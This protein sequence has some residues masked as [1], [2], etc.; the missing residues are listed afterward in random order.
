MR[1]RRAFSF[2]TKDALFQSSNE[3]QLQPGVLGESEEVLGGDKMIHR[4]MNHRCQGLSPWFKHV[5][6]SEC[7]KT[8]EICHYESKKFHIIPCHNLA[9]QK[10]LV[11]IVKDMVPLLGDRQ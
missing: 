11:L 5:F 9:V 1:K 10:Q 2:T 3:P 6:S 7:S 4:H 8:F